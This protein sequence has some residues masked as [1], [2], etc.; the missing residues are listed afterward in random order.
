MQRLLLG[1]FAL[2]ATFYALTPMRHPLI[3]LPIISAQQLK[4][5][6]RSIFFLNRK[7]IYFSGARKE[8]QAPYR[9]AVDAISQRQCLYIGIALKDF[10]WEYPFWVLLKSNLQQP[11]QLKHINVQNV[12]KKLA[13]EFP[14]SQMCAI[15]SRNYLDSPHILDNQQ[16]WQKLTLL[17]LEASEPQGYLTVYVR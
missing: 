16:S 10:E 9:A 7:D 13:P 4:E 14:D 17:P 2:T 11:F 1:L 5:Q 15:I 12:S 8:L 6:S 3:S